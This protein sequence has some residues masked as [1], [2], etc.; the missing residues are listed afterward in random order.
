M[1]KRIFSLLLTGI[2]CMGMLVGCGLEDPPAEEQIIADVNEYGIAQWVEGDGEVL[3]CEII[4]RQTNEDDKEDFV[5]CKLFTNA[6]FCQ[7]E[8]QF[9]LVY[10]YYDEGG[11][12]LEMVSPVNYEEW[13]AVG[14][15][16]ADGRPLSESMVE[17]TGNSGATN[18]EIYYEQDS[19]GLYYLF[20]SDGNKLSAGYDELYS[21]GDITDEDGN[22]I[23]HRWKACKGS[24][25]G[26][27]NDAGK[28]VIPV[29]YEKTYNDYSGFSLDAKVKE[30][31]NTFKNNF[32]QINVGDERFLMD[33]QGNVIHKGMKNNFKIYPD[34]YVF[35]W[36]V[37]DRSGNPIVDQEFG[38]I[39]A[40]DDYICCLD[41]EAERWQVYTWD[42][43]HTGWQPQYNGSHW[44]YDSEEYG[45]RYFVENYT[46]PSYIADGSGDWIANAQWNQ[47][48]Y[49][50]I[51]VSN[52]EKRGLMD[53]DGNWMLE[54]KYNWISPI[55]GG[56]YLVREESDD[57]VQ[58]EALFDW[59]GRQRTDFYE[60]I[61][62][63][64]GSRYFIVSIGEK[65]YKMP[66]PLSEEEVNECP[67]LDQGGLY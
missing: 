62:T 64:K 55:G 1:K 50:A 28:E 46:E 58:R 45:K 13:Q 38:V 30:Q 49:D 53:F 17:I 31:N 66:S 60:S 16:G 56:L 36:K 20:D 27:I 21:A 11:W 43:V 37:Y 48:G 35:G 6:D 12:V 63:L 14:F 8:S 40:T 18:D 47:N 24:K 5:H 3:D 52:G 44:C 4:K 59:K 33:E 7:M 32:V 34:G 42:G 26:F 41:G 23:D 57:G 10:T 9:E 22:I 2:L 15:L 39:N 65:N 51:I 54:G 19:D 25:F 29:T 67:A 61:N